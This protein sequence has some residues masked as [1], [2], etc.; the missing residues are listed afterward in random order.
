MQVK[1]E[2]AHLVRSFAHTAPVKGENI[3]TDQIE[4][5]ATIAWYLSEQSDRALRTF[6]TRVHEGAA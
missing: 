6:I 2:T 1:R 3:D 5:M 4:G